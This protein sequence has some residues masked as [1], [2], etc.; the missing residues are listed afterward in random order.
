MRFAVFLGLA[1]GADALQIRLGPRVKAVAN[2]GARAVAAKMAL[3]A[4]DPLVAKEFTSLQGVDTDDIV[5]EL[6]GAGIVCPPTMNDMEMRMMLIEVRMR[7]AGTFQATKKKPVKPESFASDF[8]RA[9][10]EKPAFKALYESW[11]VDKNTNAMNLAS[12]HINNVK[13]AKDRYA[14]TPN[15]VETIA[16]IEEALNAKVVREVTSSMI[17]FNGFPSNMGDA[18]VKMTLEAIG[19]VVSFSSETSDDGMTLSGRVEFED[20]AT[21]KQAVDK[22]D[23]MDMGLGTKLELE[24]V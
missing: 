8:E 23:G 12:E 20:V 22:Y 3:D 21:A 6:A 17:M 1:A 2:M 5:D 7:K 19:A 10:W 11:Q 15:Y 4:N 18:G 24:S 9:M 14:G 13:R 16:A